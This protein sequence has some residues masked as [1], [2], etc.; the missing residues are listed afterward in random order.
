MGDGEPGQARDPAW[1]VA[2]SVWNLRETNG[3]F[4]GK[5]GIWGMRECGGAPQVWNLGEKLGIWGVS[6]PGRGLSLWAGWEGGTTGMEF[7]GKNWEFGR[8]WAFGEVCGNG[9]YWELG[10]AGSGTSQ[11][12]GP[13]LSPWTWRAAPQVWNLEDKMGILG[14][15]EEPYRIWGFSVGSE[16]PP[17][18]FGV[19]MS[20]M[21]FCGS[22]WGLEETHGI[23]GSETPPR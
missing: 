5:M 2:P 19:R 18:R 17:W 23:L 22:Q 3:N 6:V 9:G 15:L 10:G 12:F 7:E 21:G 16:T 1:R 20:S 13:G 14:G 8:N 4:G 11:G